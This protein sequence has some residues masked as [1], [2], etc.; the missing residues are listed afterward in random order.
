MDKIG[1]NGRM[2]IRVGGAAACFAAILG[3]SRLAYGVLVPAMRSSIGGSFA[4]YGAIGG[5]NMVGYLAG[6]LLTTRL[7]RRP[8]RAR[9][10]T[11]ALVAMS[12]AMAAC[13][14][15]RGPLVLGILRF[16][17][18]VASGIALALTL[19]LAVERIPAARR[20]LA[21]AIVWGG[22]CAGIAI[23]GFSG[24]FVTESAWRIEWIGM[25]AFGIL[26]AA[27]YARLT[28]GTF[29][30]AER[31][32]DG[33]AIGIFAKSRYLALSI[34]YFSFGAGYIDVV[35][36]F[37]ASLGRTHG[38]SAA[39]TWTVLGLAGIVGVAIWGPLV[40]R[41]RSGVPVAFACATCAI[42]ALLVALGNAAAAVT[43]AV[44]IGIS[45]VGIPAMVGALLQQREPGVRYP[46]AFASVTVVLGVGQIAGP[47][48]GGL[49]AD[50]F[51]TPS[52]LVAG[53]AALAVAAASA[54]L[55][56]RPAETVPAE[57]AP[58]EGASGP[59]GPVALLA[60]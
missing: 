25:G 26:V 56:R 2:W 37:G 51:G 33:D 20:G 53:A 8:D 29:A 28:G 35:T 9:V 21:A 54:L 38:M 60:T 41:F 7:A 15:A 47:I 32:D 58:A 14:L 48:A 46:R 17:V 1:H 18:G 16:G 45:F 52:A 10:N 49:I 42:G 6:S 55:Y 44:A 24:R 3:F 59:L 4:L 5:A 19:S 30:A 34:A 40:D 36:F 43:G 13:G 39:T 50:A 11:I 57:S 12:V 31:A 27:L 23:A 22:G